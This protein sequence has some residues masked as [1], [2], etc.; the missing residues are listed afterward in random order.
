MSSLIFYTDPEQALV[1]TDTLAVTT[2][3]APFLFTSKAHYIPHLRLIVAG[4]GFGSFADDWCRTINT[5]MLVRGVENL[6]H[7]APAML[8]DQWA[9]VSNDPTFPEGRTTTIYHFGI[10]EETERVVTFAYRSTEGFKGTRLPENGVGVKPECEVP[11]GNLL[12]H[13]ESMMME[14]RRLQALA[15]DDRRI[16]IG[17][18]AF[19]MHLTATSC[20]HSR[21]FRFKDFDDQ[22]AQAFSSLGK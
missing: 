21:L 17:G 4:T 20:T 3:G 14:Q 7:H 15:P 9:H 19:A 10:S 12:D 1:V 6:H 5:R 8:R 2:D 18:E 22:V 11:D 13:L 16:H